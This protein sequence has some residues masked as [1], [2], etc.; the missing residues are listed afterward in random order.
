M[1]SRS[2]NCSSHISL[3]DFFFI[4][5]CKALGGDLKTEMS[6]NFNQIIIQ[7]NDNY[8]ENISLDEKITM[9]HLYVHTNN[10]YTCK[11]AAGWLRLYFYMF[12]L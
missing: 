2:P 11:G 6:G 12:V 10:G 3:I 9:T 8:R 4:I 1:T 7:R 5:L